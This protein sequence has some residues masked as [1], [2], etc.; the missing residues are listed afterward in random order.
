V[1]TLAMQ[2]RCIEMIPALLVMMLNDLGKLPDIPNLP[3]PGV[4]GFRK[5]ELSDM[6]AVKWLAEWCG[7]RTDK[8]GFRKVAGLACFRDLYEWHS[9]SDIRE[10]VAIRGSRRAVANLTIWMRDDARSHNRRLSGS[11]ERFDVGLAQLMARLGGKPTT[12]VLWEY[13]P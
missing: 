8:D 5:P 7:P 1:T 12:R 2:T 4:L 6:E 13:L 11:F 3:Q 10:V 9:A